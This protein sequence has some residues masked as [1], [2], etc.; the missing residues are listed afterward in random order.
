MFGRLFV[1]KRLSTGKWECLCECGN[2]KAVAANNLRA[3]HIKSCGCLV[4]EKI[5][6]HSH[7]KKGKLSSEYYT[8][9]GMKTRCGNPNVSAYRNYGGRGI[10]VCKR[11]ESFEFFLADMGVKPS[12]GYEI[13]R[14]NV[15]GN[16]EPGNCRWVLPSQNALN[17]RQTGGGVA[18][19]G[20]TFIAR[21]NKYRAR[22]VANDKRV[23]LGVFDSAK[24]AAMAYDTAARQHHGE[25]AA[26]NK[27]LGLL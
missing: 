25:Y 1:V 8:W 24:D 13:D 21:N 7:A 9:V 17:R 27:S 6:T 19:K 10:S 5:T 20:V 2:T 4:L 23:H 16:Y 26:T 3:G 11:W 22:I 18:Y 12:K 15:N 14:I